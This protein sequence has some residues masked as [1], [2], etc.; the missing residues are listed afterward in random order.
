MKTRLIVATLIACSLGC[1]K[2]VQTVTQ[3][4]PSSQDRPVSAKASMALMEFEQSHSKKRSG[5]PSFGEQRGQTPID[6]PEKTRRFETIDPIFHYE[7]FTLNTQN[8]ENNEGENLKI[9]VVGDNYITIKGKRYDLMQFHFHRTSEHALKG[10]K[11][12]MEAHLVHSSWEGELAVI[13]VFMEVTYRE[14][15]RLEILFENIPE[16]PDQVISVD[17]RFNPKSL[18][19]RSSGSYFTYNGS[20]TTPA[21][22]ENLTWIVFESPIPVSKEQVHTYAEVF[23]ELNVRPLQPISGR[24]IWEARDYR[25]R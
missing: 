1:Q 4:T 2:E 3:Q 17:G 9:E 22:T 14:N 5:F 7:D 18:L 12:G 23:E 25:I 16:I 20:L 11:Y 13:G 6:I 15:E 24:T 8:V 10:K 21:F 19:P